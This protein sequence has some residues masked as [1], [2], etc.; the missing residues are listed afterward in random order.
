MTGSNYAC[1]PKGKV[2]AI[3]LKIIR[4]FSRDCRASYK[5]I[6]LTVGI[7]PNAIKERINTMVCNG[8]IQSFIVNVNPA[9]FEYEKECLLMLK[10]F[11]RTTSTPAKTVNDNI[12]KQLN[13]IGEVRF[14][15]KLLQG[16]MYVLSL[17][18]GTEDKISILGE[19]LKEYAYSVE[20]TFINYTPISMKVIGSDFKIIKCLLSN[21]RKQVEDIA[22]D[23]SLSTKTV[24]RR[25]EKLKENHAIEF[26][27]MRNMSTM[28]LI[29]YIEFGVKVNLEDSSRYQYVLERIY[30]EMEEYLFVIPHAHQLDS[31]FLVFSCPN[32][33]SV[34]WILTRMQ[35]YEGVNK[36]AVFIT[37]KLVYYQDWVQREID[38]R[39]RLQLEK[40]QNQEAPQQHPHQQQLTKQKR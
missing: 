17:R 35:G 9:L 14:Y 5:D 8:I 32:I 30:K 24:T 36:L 33:A 4:L 20:Y 31:I 26:G 38:R 16:S 1:K 12:V 15:A 10:H 21:P 23:T 28:Q 25:L 7:T 18:T 27:I 3:D 39:L 37:T 13:L 29:G 22:K 34:D 11:K 19:L 2:D 6:S 40:E